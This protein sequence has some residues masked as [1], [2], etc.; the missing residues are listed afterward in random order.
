MNISCAY[1][2]S[3]KMTSGVNQMKYVFINMALS[4][5]WRPLAGVT[6][7]WY[8]IKMASSSFVNGWKWPKINYLS[9][10]NK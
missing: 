2:Y 4:T 5:T 9:L 8:T 1:D 3:S 10:D 6:S 7:N